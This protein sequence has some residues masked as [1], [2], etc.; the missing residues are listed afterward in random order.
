MLHEYYNF[1]LIT[2]FLFILL[3]FYKRNNNKLFQ[4][5]L[6][7]SK[8]FLIVLNHFKLFWVIIV[9]IVNIVP[10]II[11]SHFEMFKI[12]WKKKIAELHDLG[13]NIQKLCFHGLWFQ[14]LIFWTAIYVQGMKYPLLRLNTNKARYTLLSCGQLSRISNAKTAR[15]SKM[16]RIYWPT[17]QPTDT[18]RCNW[19]FATKN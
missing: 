2:C 1:Y 18:A 4:V 7:Y 14:K 12:I 6:T 3:S 5:I 11:L 15:N 8:S 16:W 9:I 10:Y 17:Y 19:V 13:K